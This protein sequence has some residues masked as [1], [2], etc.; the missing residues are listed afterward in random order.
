M[1]KTVLILDAQWNKETS[2]KVTVYLEEQPRK[3]RLPHIVS[4]GQTDGYLESKSS[5]ANKK[6]QLQK[7]YWREC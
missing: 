4:N 1:N 7:I 5:F 3:L 2:K 6:T